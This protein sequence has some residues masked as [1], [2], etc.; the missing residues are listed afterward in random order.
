LVAKTN[1]P[2][3]THPFHLIYNVKQQNSET[4]RLREQDDIQPTS[5]L[6]QYKFSNNFFHLT[7]VKTV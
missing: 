4:I 6:R 2:P 3:F 1:K 7:S 5:C